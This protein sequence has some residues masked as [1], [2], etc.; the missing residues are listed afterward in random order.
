MLTSWT[1][2][3]THTHTQVKNS[4]KKLY[5]VLD[6]GTL[7][8]AAD[9]HEGVSYLAATGVLEDQPHSIAEF[10]HHTSLLDWRSLERFLRDRCECVCVCVRVGFF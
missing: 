3:P 9:P 10:I 5:L 2:T 8:F 4:Y 6:N 7:T 1:H